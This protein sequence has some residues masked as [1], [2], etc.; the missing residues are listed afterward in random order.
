MLR[1]TNI[2][3]IFVFSLGA[4]ADDRT[5]GN[6]S[7]EPFRVGGQK[8]LVWRAWRHGRIAER[9]DFVDVS[10]RIH[11]FGAV[12]RSPQ[13]ATVIRKGQTGRMPIAM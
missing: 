1:F 9:V 5:V 8:I 6:V 10:H 11:F 12:G 3:L 2:L 7:V 13:Q 4:L